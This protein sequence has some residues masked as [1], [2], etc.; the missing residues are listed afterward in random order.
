MV[1]WVPTFYLV[2][3]IKEASMMD[4]IVPWVARHFLPY[5]FQSCSL[6]SSFHLQVR[7]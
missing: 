2:F 7:T 5:D 4:P 6:T 1:G 3:V